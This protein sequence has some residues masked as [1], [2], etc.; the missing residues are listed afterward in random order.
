[1]SNACSPHPMVDLEWIRLASGNPSLSVRECLEKQD[2]VG[3]NILFDV[4]YYRQ[5]YGHD[6]PRHMSALEHFCRQDETSLRNPNAL[7]S[8]QQWLEVFRGI[9]PNAGPWREELVRALG[10][11]AIFCRN[12]YLRDQNDE[13]IFSDTFVGKAPSQT[14]DICLFV[15]YDRHDEIQPYVVDY[16]QALKDCG[17]VT[18]FLSNTE[19]FSQKEINKIR[20]IVWRVVCADNRGRDWS[21]FLQG[22]KLLEGQY[23]RNPILIANDSVTY[24][25]EGLEEMMVQ[26]RM[27]PERIT[28]AIGAN[29]HG[30]HMQSFFLYCGRQVVISEAWLNFWKKFRSHHNKWFVINANEFGFSR[31]MLEHKIPMHALWNYDDIISGENRNR[32]NK[33]REAVFSRE[34]LTNPTHE[35]WDILLEHKYPFIKNSI[36]KEAIIGENLDHMCN[37]ISRLGNKKVRDTV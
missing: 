13:I 19:K 27:H 21:L 8:T 20:N 9:S 11:E 37:I 23:E 12:E 34:I 17:V 33:W 16:L 15:H 18:I 32:A 22:M 3:P 36:F 30:W 31:W 24:V 2:T 10:Q 7:F 4:E 1:M 14:D 6:I 5:K 35:L 25:G 28:G 26:C 29:Q